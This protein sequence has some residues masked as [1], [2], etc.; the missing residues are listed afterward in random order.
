[1]VGGLRDLVGAQLGDELVLP[2]VA[3]LGVVDDLA[4]HLAV[5]HHLVDHVGAVDAL[6][7]ADDAVALEGGL[8]L[9]EQVD[10]G[11]FAQLVGAT[12]LSSLRCMSGS[13]DCSLRPWPSR[14][15]R[16]RPSRAAGPP[17]AAAGL[18]GP[19]R[20][21]SRRPPPAR[22]SGPPSARRR[23]ALACSACGQ[24]RLE[25]G[26]PRGLAGSRPRAWPRRAR[27]PP[28]ARGGS[29]L[30]ARL[31][32]GCLV[33]LALPGPRSCGRCPGRWA[34]RTWGSG[35]PLRARVLER[36]AARRLEQTH[37]DP[38]SCF[39]LTGGLRAQL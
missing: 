28:C 27:R 18:P 8:E 4:A 19:R 11:A 35:R 36:L 20:R 26:E 1:M 2:G 5:V 9:L 32:Q 25:L 10:L 23:R 6:A 39:A 22:P 30:G 14:P 34:A 33:L 15:A 3:V 24:L 13:S 21:A 38:S 7:D 17:S 29:R 16:R 31:R 12:C 37:G